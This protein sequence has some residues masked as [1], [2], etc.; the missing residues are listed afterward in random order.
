MLRTVK[1]FGSIY[2]V[3]GLLN[4]FFGTFLMVSMSGMSSDRD[5]AELS[6]CLWS[7]KFNSNFDIPS[8]IKF[9]PSEGW[10]RRE[11]F[12]PA[13]F[14]PTWSRIWGTAWRA[15]KIWPTPTMFTWALGAGS[16]SG[17]LAGSE[18]LW[19]T[20]WGSGPPWPWVWHF[21]GWAI[22]LS[23][24]DRLWFFAWILVLSGGYAVTYFC[25]D[26]GLWACMLSMGVCTGLAISLCFTNINTTVMKVNAWYK[27]H[28]IIFIHTKSA[29]V[30]Q[31]ERAHGE[32]SICRKWLWIYHLDTPSD[33]L[34]KPG[35]YSSCG[36]WWWRWQVNIV[37]DCWLIT[38]WGITSLKLLLD[39]LWTKTYLTG[40]LAYF[41]C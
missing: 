5:S 36:S 12:F 18:G 27:L 34:C 9:C 15:E 11:Y 17:W 7:M 22:L 20:S 13:T 29:V 28:P 26:A 16:S 21:T 3:R 6:S 35:K 2:P 25:V 24:S 40:F 10:Q 14:W 41:Y 39:I 38:A 33:Y 4:V 1:I 37:N 31:Q 19:P 23:S 8:W 30:S 32:H